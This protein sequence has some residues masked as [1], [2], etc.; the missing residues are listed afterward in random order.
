[1]DRELNCN[2]CA[3]ERKGMTRLKI[4]LMVEGLIILPSRFKSALLCMVPDNRSTGAHPFVDSVDP[5][6]KCW[7]ERKSML[8]QSS[9]WRFFYSCTL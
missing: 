2:V 4:A 5:F 6:Q 8:T 7:M 9:H 1:M 3:R